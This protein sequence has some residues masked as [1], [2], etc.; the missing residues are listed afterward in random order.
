MRDPQGSRPDHTR[1]FLCK[2][3]QLFQ[4]ILN[5]SLSRKPLQE[6]FC[7][8][9]SRGRCIVRIY[10]LIDPRINSFVP[11]ARMIIISAIILPNIWVNSVVRGMPV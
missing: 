3:V 5:F 10:S 8:L 7:T 2:A 6:F 9:V 1:L 11:S 4:S